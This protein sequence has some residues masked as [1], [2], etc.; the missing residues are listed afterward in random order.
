LDHHSKLPY[1]IVSIWEITIKESLG[2][3]ELSKGWKTV[4]TEFNFSG[5]Q[6]VCIEFNTFRTLSS[7]PLGHCYP[8]D[9]LLI[10]QAIVGDIILLSPDTIFKQYT[11]DVVR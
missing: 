4:K 6:Q 9:R 10:S 2:R 8:F 1:S 5:I 11:V 7:L 3:I